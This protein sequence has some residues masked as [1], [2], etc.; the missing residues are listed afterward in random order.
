VHPRWD[1]SHV[2]Q[3]EKSLEEIVVTGPA[4]VRLIPAASCRI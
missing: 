2:L 1:L 3:G 4:G